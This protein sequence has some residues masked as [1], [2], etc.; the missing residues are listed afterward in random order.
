M[1]ENMTLRIPRLL[2]LAALAAVFALCMGF[3]AAPSYAAGTHT[4][5]V[6]YAGNWNDFDASNLKDTPQTKLTLYKVGD[7]TKAGDSWDITLA[8]PLSNITLTKEEIAA[9]NSAEDE[10]ARIQAWLEKA[11]VIDHEIM[12]VKGLAEELKAATTS[13]NPQ[14]FDSRTGSAVFYGLEQGIYL[15]H[16]DSWAEEVNGTATKYWCPQPML[17]QVITEKTEAN[18]KPVSKTPVDEIT[19]VKAWAGKGNE[20]AR[21]TSIEVAVAYD[22]TVVETVTLSEA[23]SWK[24]VIKTPDGKKDPLKWTAAE[25]K[26]LTDFTPSIRVSE[27]VDGK[28]TINITNTYN[29]QSRELELIKVLPVFV[30]HGDKVSTAFTFEITGYQGSTVAYH[31]Y[32]GLS[33]DKA[34]RRSTKITGIPLGL[35]RVVVREVSSAGYDVNGSAQKEAQLDGNT[36]EVSFEN[37][38]DDIRYEGGV[39]NKYKQTGGKYHFDSREGVVRK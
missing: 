11:A 36:Y 38:F 1:T 16:G 6:K 23:N 14:S 10:S 24:A 20:D 26:V 29:V 21:P 3:A 5:T 25:V 13:A 32:A 22:G 39:I 12:T 17:V 30:D 15:I 18:L 27:V 28:M 4:L 7:C 37:T 35:S 2:L 8:A 33:F 31:R 9:M 19:I 34:G